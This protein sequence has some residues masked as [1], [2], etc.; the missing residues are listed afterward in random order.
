MLVIVVAYLGRNSSCFPTLKAC[1]SLWLYTFFS[2]SSKP[3][4]YRLSDTLNKVGFLHETL[5]CLNF[6][7]HSPMFTKPAT[8]L[9]GER[10]CHFKR[11][12]Q[13][14]NSQKL[15]SQASLASSS[16]LRILSITGDLWVWELAYILILRRLFHFRSLL[17]KSKRNTQCHST[18]PIS[19]YIILLNVS[20][21][22]K[23][24]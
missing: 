22:S 13:T 2:D 12:E 7:L 9:L 19:S 8:K 18:F 17:L 5:V 6:R 16:V 21:T 23:N 10:M 11:T 24:L 14:L 20:L 15:S 1:L 3:S 4:K